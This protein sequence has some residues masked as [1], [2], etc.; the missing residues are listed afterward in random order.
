MSKIE[1]ADWYKYTGGPTTEIDGLIFSTLDKLIDG[2]NDHDTRL[3]N[4][5][6]WTKKEDDTRLTP[7]TSAWFRMLEI[8]TRIKALDGKTFS[9]PD[10]ILPEH[11]SRTEQ[12]HWECGECGKD[13]EQFFTGT[14][15]TPP[16]HCATGSVAH[17][18]GGCG[19]NA[20]KWIEPKAEP[21]EKTEGHWECDECGKD[22]GSG[23]GLYEHGVPDEEDRVR[24]L[25]CIG[26]SFGGCNSIAVKWIEPKAD[27]PCPDCNGSGKEIC[28]NP[29]HGGIA[30]SLYGAENNRLGCP[31][32]GHDP[33]HYTGLK[34][35]TCG[36]TGVIPKE[37]TEGHWECSECG[38]IITGSRIVGWHKKGSYYCNCAKS[39]GQTVSWIE[40]KE[41]A[42][43]ESLKPCLY[44]DMQVSGA[45]F[46]DVQVNAEWY[47]SVLC[48]ACGAHGPRTDT[49]AEAIAAWN[50]RADSE[51]LIK[52]R[53][54]IKSLEEYNDEVM[55]KLNKAD[56]YNLSDAVEVLTAENAELKAQIL[57]A[58]PYLEADN[59]QEAIEIFTP[60]KENTD[61]PIT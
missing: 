30:A 42:E 13:W 56:P 57:Q 48:P 20:V 8:E 7:G 54:K 59:C 32:C 46:T 47:K 9:S 35:E 31:G 15:D 61:E 52:A 26:G 38:N 1:K 34:C 53:A 55:E 41:K 51:E 2:H 37:K 16:F 10:D 33:D 25:I 28:D 18:L 43:P 6:Q 29:D 23:V 39:L 40:P 49:E 3:D 21:K 24:R 27:M 12:G 45:V 5:E 58:M 44:C 14:F 4:F 17:P 11:A 19:K 50:R 60:P 22:W 36:G